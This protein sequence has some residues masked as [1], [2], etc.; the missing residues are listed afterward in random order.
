MTRSKQPNLS[1]REMLAV[2]TVADYG[3]FNA[4][5]ITL[6]ISQPVLTRTIQRVEAQLGITLFDRNTR[7]VEITEAGKEFVALSE[8]VLNDMQI[9]MQAIEQRSDQK[10]GQVVISSVMSVACTVLPKIIARYKQSHPGVDLYIYEGVHGNVIENVRS[11]VADFGLTYLDDI[12]PMFEEK[13]LSTEAFHVVLSKG[14]P[15]QKRKQVAWEALKNEQLIS[16]PADSRTRRLIDATATT[17]GFQLRHN[18]TVTQFTSMMQFVA[19]G[20]G[21]AI[22]PEGSLAGALNIGLATRPLVQPKVSRVLGLVT[23]KERSHSIFAQ[24]MMRQIEMDWKVL[25]E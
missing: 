14:H 8:R 2:K 19:D 15:L 1:A 6:N 10:R 3:S 12:S 25:R 20:V 23:L 24:E 21:I 22:V 11:S 17:S 13:P 9:Y 18:I 5:A 7:S 16:L 4:A